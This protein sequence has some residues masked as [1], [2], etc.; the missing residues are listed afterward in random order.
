MDFEKYR[1]RLFDYLKYKKLN[2]IYGLNRCFNP[3]H[4]DK[5]P[6][7]LIT[8]KLYH[9][10]SAECGITGDIYDAIGIL[11]GIENIS[12]QYDFAEKLFREVSHENNS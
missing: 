5:T 8:E 2:P 9:C 4:E 11:E 12:E 10:Y 3:A 6:S 1:K 7:C